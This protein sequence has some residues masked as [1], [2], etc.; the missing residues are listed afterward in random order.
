[1]IEKTTTYHNTSIPLVSVLIPCYNARQTVDDAIASIIHQSL[2]AWGLILID[3]GSTDG[4]LDLLLVW[5]ARDARVCVF[6]QPHAGVI[7]AL[8][9]GL[10]FCKTEYIARMDA[11]DLASPHRLG[12]QV[13]FLDSH[14]DIAVVGCLVAGYPPDGIGEGFRP[15]LE[16]MNRLIT[17]DEITSEI[18]I[19]S[20][21]AHPSVMARK[22]WFEFV[23]GYQEHGW[24]EDYDLWLRL[25][26]AGAR[27]AKVPE[28]MISWCEHPHRLT[29]M[30][31]RYSAD[32]FL[33]AKAHYLCQGA[34][35]DRDALFIWGAGQIGRKLSKLLIGYGVPLKAF[36]DVDPRKLGHKRLARDVLP[37]DMLL[38]AW[39]RFKRPVL[40]AAVGSRAPDLPSGN[41]SA[42]WDCGKLA[43]GGR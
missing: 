31:P 28:I 34:L 39:I 4:T 23:G 2:K 6:H 33:G 38:P 41:I 27:F 16:W 19:E 43:I 3:D 36:I 24:P 8:N 26:I 12:K 14:P 32:A 22:S 21:L 25:H 13:A 30:D 5:E 18:Y 9:G 17:H 15:Y 40:L 29:H 11:D 37:P 10:R 7:E 42:R 1:V 20:P 35:K